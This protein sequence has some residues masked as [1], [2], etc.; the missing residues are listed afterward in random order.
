MARRLQTRRVVMSAA[1]GLVG[2]TSL[3]LTPID[4]QAQAALRSD[5]PAQRTAETCSV[6]PELVPSCGDWWGAAVPNTGSNLSEAVA[7]TEFETGRRLDIVHT[8]HRWTQDFPTASELALARS[9]HILLINWQPTDD[10]DKPIAWQ[11]IADGSQDQVIAAEAI[12][13]KAMGT[14]VMISFSH[15]PEANIDTEG[16]ASQY[17]AAYRRVHD[18]VVAAGATNVVWV[19]DIEGI[20]TSHWF[21]L[22]RRFWP[23]ADYVDWIAWDPYNF[24]SCR[25]LPWRSFDALVAPFYRWIEQ[26]PFAHRPL[27][28][29]EY[30][31]IGNIAGP[32]SKQRWYKG[33]AASLSAFPAIKSVVYFDYPR[34]PASC[35]WASNSSPAAA[36]SFAA[37]AKS[38]AFRATSRLTPDA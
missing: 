18:V 22:Y 14:P 12:R 2:F 25:G 3:V 5:T 8:Y 29:A 37:L 21:S 35:N 4:L 23:G 9:G 36:A 33:E 19:W 27:M 13:L 10:E 24:A 16:S 17:V 26:Q 15:E 32:H 38:R 31:T 11:A 6:S 34:P 7:D 28:L 1:A 20:A 30:G